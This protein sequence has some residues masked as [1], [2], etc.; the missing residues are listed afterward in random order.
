MPNSWSWW[1]KEEEEEEEEENEED[2]DGRA[3][4]EHDD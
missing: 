4:G 2:W 3:G 1:L